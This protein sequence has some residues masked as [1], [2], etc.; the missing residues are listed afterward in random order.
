MAKCGSMFSSNFLKTAKTNGRIR[1]NP[2]SKN[3]RS[4]YSSYRDEKAARNFI[5]DRRD[6]AGRDHPIRHRPVSAFFE[7]RKSKSDRLDQ[8]PDRVVNDRSRGR[9]R[10]TR[11]GWNG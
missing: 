2:N 7:T 4:P 6:A 1:A 8:G 9:G 3:D 10:E 5:D 11:A